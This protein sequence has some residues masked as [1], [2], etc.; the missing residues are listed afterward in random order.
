MLGAGIE[1][2]QPAAKLMLSTK[3]DKRSGQVHQETLDKCTDTEEN[4]DRELK[5]AQ[6]KRVRGRKRL[7]YLGRLWG[8]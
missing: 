4:K 6:G 1:M 7:I 8:Q 5:V 2:K 3:Y